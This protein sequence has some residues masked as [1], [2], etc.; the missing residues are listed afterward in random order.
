MRPRPRFK[1]A[2]SGVDATG[3]GCLVSPYDYRRGYLAEHA[4]PLIEGLA[5]AHSQVFG[6]D[7]NDTKSAMLSTW[8]DTNAFNEAGIPAICYGART[9]DDNMGGGLAGEH[10]PMAVADLIALAKV[11][12]L[13]ALEVC[14]VDA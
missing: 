9:T 3:L 6:E 7:L 10:R 14:K 11:Y 8:R 12:A 13:T 5:N 1:P 4:E 2:Y